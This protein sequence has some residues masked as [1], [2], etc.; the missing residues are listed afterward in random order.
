MSKKVKQWDRIRAKLKKGFEAKG[1]T[2]CEIRYKDCWVNN[3]LS[4]AHLDKRRYLTE[5]QLY[6]VVLACVLCH[7]QVEYLPKGQM[8]EIL[9]KVIDQRDEK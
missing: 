4:F 6:E 2:T 5:E 9:Q 8:R 7:D 3:G 1:I